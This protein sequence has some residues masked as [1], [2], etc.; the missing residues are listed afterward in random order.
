MKYFLVY[1]TLQYDGYE[2]IT[3]QVFPAESEEMAK[4]LAQSEDYTHG[5]GIEVQ[6]V[7]VVREISKSDAA[8]LSK[9]L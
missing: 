2:W 9:Y 4:K 7:N 3:K 6:W 8:V 1:I 5:N